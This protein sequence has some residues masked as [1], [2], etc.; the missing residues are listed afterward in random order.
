IQFIF[1]LPGNI[2]F[3][4][5]QVALPRAINKEGL[6]IFYSP[7]YKV[8]LN[9]KCIVVSAILDLMYIIY[10]KYKNKLNFFSESY[11]KHF[12]KLYAERSNI[13]LTCSE[14]SK[15]DIIDIF[16]IDPEKIKIIPLSVSNMYKP[17]NDIEKISNAKAKYG[18][19]GRYIYYIGNFKHHK[20][21]EN[22]IIAFRKL[23]P[24]FKDLKLVL[25]GPKTHLYQQYL[26]LIKVLSIQNSVIF[27]GRILPEDEPH[28]LYNGA[29]VFV[30][31]SLYEGFG[32]PPIEAMAC[33]TPVI[34]S[35]L[36]SLP[37]VIS[38][39]GILVDPCNTDDL[40]TAISSILSN[41]SLKGVLIEK[42][43]KRAEKFSQ[44]IISKQYYDFFK[45]LL[46]KKDT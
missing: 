27:T 39:A 46:K 17:E 10:E 14:Y 28:L 30:F 44:E 21:V 38:S 3:L 32:I 20:N 26:S 11:Y 23:L 25:A 37:E 12:G 5:D 15:K 6:D 43:F 22:L 2:I 1:I 41:N 42:G 34:S 29:E 7:Y 35:N 13:I 36:T 9:A 33:G 40:A 8:P 16:S 24:K 31:P 45:K 4:W 18:I 19:E